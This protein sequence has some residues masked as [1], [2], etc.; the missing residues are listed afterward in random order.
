MA[1]AGVA[2]VAAAL[3]VAGCTTSPSAARQWQQVPAEAAS[4]AVQKAVAGE[5]FSPEVREITPRG[6]GSYPLASSGLF[7]LADPLS[8]LADFEPMVVEEDGG[9]RIVTPYYSVFVPDQLFP[10]G[11]DYA[12]SPAMPE[13]LWGEGL[14]RGCDLVVTPAGSNVPAVQ[15]YVSSANWDGVQGEAVALSAGPV[16]GN[17]SFHVV[18]AG[19]ADYSA[20]P[21]GRRAREDL[22]PAYLLVSPG[23]VAAREGSEGWAV[24]EVPGAATL[25]EGEDGGAEIVAPGYA[26][27]VD[28]ALWPDGCLY[29]YYGEHVPLTNGDAREFL[30]LFDPEGPAA[31]CL[32]CA[33]EGPVEDLESVAGPRFAW[34]EAP[35]ADHVYVGAAT[36]ELARSYA[37]CIEG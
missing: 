26:V 13:G 5:G 28:G 30:A 32:V 11:F 2:A 24:V 19:P 20:D 12:Y 36:E 25:A 9:S 22:Y 7:G 17:P 3:G 1:A 23:V 6:A 27:R 35:G 34:V 8:E 37:V 31:A 15:V 18:V 33:Y 16:A 4:G 29:R 21:D 10:D 14:Y